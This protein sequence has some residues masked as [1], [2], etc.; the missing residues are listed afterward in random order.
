MTDCSNLLV[1]GAMITS[2][3]VNNVIILL[4][5]C[6]SVTNWPSATAMIIRLTWP[7]CK[8]IVWLL[9]WCLSV[10]NYLSVSGVITSR[11]VFPRYSC[12]YRNCASQIFA[13]Q[14]FSLSSQR[15]RNCDNQVNAWEFSTFCDISLP[16]TS[17]LCTSIVQIVMIFWRSLLVSL[18]MSSMIMAFNWVICRAENKIYFRLKQTNKRKV[19]DI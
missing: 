16:T 7:A 13:K 15:W 14:S 1:I 8:Q 10:M 17:R 5:T 4:Y 19:Y 11:G 18:P 3:T 12:W 2:L 9:N 6:M